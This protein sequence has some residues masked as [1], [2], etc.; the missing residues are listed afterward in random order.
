MKVIKKYAS[1]WNDVPLLLQ[2]TNGN[3]DNVDLASSID[4]EMRGI[5]ARGY[6]QKKPGRPLNIYEITIRKIDTVAYDASQSSKM[7][8]KVKKEKK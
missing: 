8:T 2:R 5:L 6:A 3:A 1:R 7:F 4:D